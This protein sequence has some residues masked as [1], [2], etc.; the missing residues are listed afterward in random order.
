MIPFP[1]HRTLAEVAWCEATLAR[2]WEHLSFPERHQLVQM[3]AAI[4]SGLANYPKR[5]SEPQDAA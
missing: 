3:L 5:N 1:G 2:D 4:P